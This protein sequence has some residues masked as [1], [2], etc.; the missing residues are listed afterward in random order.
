MRITIDQGSGEVR[1]SDVGV[2]KIVIGRD[3]DCDLVLDDTLV[4]RRHAEIER[5]EDGR[6]YVSDLGSTNGTLLNGR[7]IATAEPFTNRDIVQIGS[8]RIRLPGGGPETRLASGTVVG[9]PK[10]AAGPATMERQVLR[11]SVED[12]TKRANIAVMALVGALVVAL[13]AVGLVGTGIVSLGPPSD[14]QLIAA[15]RPST[16]YVETLVAAEP[17]SSGTGWALNAESRQIVTNFH[18]VSG[19]TSFKVGFPPGDLTPATLLAAAPCEDLA[20]LTATTPVAGLVTMPLGRQ[21]DVAIGDPVVAVGYPETISGTATVVGS[22][23]IVSSAKTD[24]GFVIDYPTLPNIIQTDAA[25]NPGNSGG[26]LL[27]AT[28]ELVGVNTLGYFGQGFA[29]G[30]APNQNQNYAIGVDRVKEVTAILGDG[31]SMGYTGMNFG[32]FVTA[33]TLDQYAT[34]LTGLGLPTVPGIVVLDVLP[35]SP[36]ADVGLGS[37]PVIITAIADV[38]VSTFPDY[39]TAV[40]SLQ[41]GETAVFTMIPAGAVDPVR[42]EVRFL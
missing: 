34:A 29:F 30:G 21:A 10:R 28:K 4:S 18:V 31:R 22:K 6:T 17:Q 8:S 2:D 36:A 11:R 35:G 5:R 38:P 15:A 24:S 33:E 41:T 1:E 40:G 3:P 32:G 16:V 39:C 26:P 23:G 14:A 9:E 42:I 19:G 12:A 37:T 7:R 27:S 13:V 20:M 25:I